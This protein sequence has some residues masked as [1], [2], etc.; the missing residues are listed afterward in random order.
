MNEPLLRFNKKQKYLVFD[1]ETEGLNLVTSRPWQIAWLV[2]EGDR[3]IKKND[4][5]IQWP[6][7]NVSEG[8]A[9]ITGFSRK[10]YEKKCQSPKEVWEKFAEDF[11]D[12]ETL[13][14]GQNV[15]GFD[16]YMLNIWRKLIGLPSTYEYLP[17][18]IDTRA[19]AVAIA[20][21]IPVEKKDFL[22]WQ[23]RLLNYR[24]RGLRTSQAAL[25]KQY[26]IPHDPKRLHDAL[27]DIE[28]N[29]KIF[30]KQLFQ[31]EI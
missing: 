20:K 5:F 25:L 15:L 16:I 4:L 22:C 10:E 30:C 17:R 13:I 3:I 8:A 9:R 19:L 28:M 31:L 6:D 29:F 24:E 2:A 21:Q 26:N 7:L 27:Y 18:M 14:V 1:T 12:S 11:G 23:Y